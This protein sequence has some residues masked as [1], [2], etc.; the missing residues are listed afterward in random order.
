MAKAV[1]ASG[2]AADR[3]DGRINPMTEDDRVWQ[4]MRGDELL[5]ELVVTG[6]DFPWLTGTLRPTSGFEEVRPLFQDE[7]F[8]LDHLDDEPG[9]WEA[10]YRRIRQAMRLLAPDGRPVPE[11]LLHIDG[12]N[13]WWRWSDQLWP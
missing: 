3:R 7:L 4:L 6:T 9:T 1:T 11:F 2:S 8:R 10:A 5:A 13:A 12:G